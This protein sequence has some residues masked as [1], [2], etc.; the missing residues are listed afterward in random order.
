MPRSSIFGVRGVEPGPVGSTPRDTTPIGRRT[1]DL[2]TAV[3]LGVAVAAHGG[4]R[5]HLGTSTLP[6]RLS[7]VLPTRP[8]VMDGASAQA[9]GRHH[10]GRMYQ[11]ASEMFGAE[12]DDDLFDEV[13]AL[14]EEIDDDL[15]L[16][17]D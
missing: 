4:G 14:L 3:D 8:I 17:L 6:P 10:Y 7:S 16:D 9:G 12:D 15:D 11:D 1:P 2:G 13:D 5:H